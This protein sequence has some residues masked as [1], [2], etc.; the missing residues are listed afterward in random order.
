MSRSLKSLLADPVFSGRQQ[1]EFGDEVSELMIRNGRGA[2]GALY[3]LSNLPRCYEAGRPGIT[4][5][6]HHFV[7]EKVREW[8]SPKEGECTEHDLQRVKKYL[9]VLVALYHD[10]EYINRHEWFGHPIATL[11]EVPTQE[12]ACVCAA[13]LVLAIDDIPVLDGWDDGR[14]S[15]FLNEF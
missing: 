11:S 14:I 7:L 5:T 8:L 10:L 15:A 1:D 12:R 3:C 9:S 4:N 2:S 6:L 13:A